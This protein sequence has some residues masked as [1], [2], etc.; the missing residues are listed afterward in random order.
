MNPDLIKAMNRE[1]NQEMP[2]PDF[3]SEHQQASKVVVLVVGMLL[4]YACGVLSG[5]AIAWWIGR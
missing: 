3:P 4:G 2:E 5:V 1:A